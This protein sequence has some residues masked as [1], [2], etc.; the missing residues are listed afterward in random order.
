MIGLFYYRL[1]SRGLSFEIITKWIFRYGKAWYCDR[2]LVWL[3]IY[4]W[5]ILLDHHHLLV[6]STYPILSFPYLII[7]E[8]YHLILS[9]MAYCLTILARLHYLHYNCIKSFIQLWLHFY[10]LAG[11][12]RSTCTTFLITHWIELQH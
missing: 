3:I 8:L 5:L 12:Y 11:H 1:L 4:D 9:F 10:Y 6:Y 7:V 2:L